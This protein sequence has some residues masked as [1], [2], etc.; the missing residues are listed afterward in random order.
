M[1]YKELMAA[2]Q[3]RADEFAKPIA[4]DIEGI[5]R[6]FVRKRTVAEF[7]AMADMEDK[8]HGKFAPALARIICEGSG[9]RFPAEQRDQIA[10]LLALQPEATFHTIISASDGTGKQEDAKDEGN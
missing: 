3:V 8:G 2:L 5:G 1:N 4:V 7:E 10:A 9:A 6:I